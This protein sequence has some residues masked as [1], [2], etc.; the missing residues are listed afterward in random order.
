M[1]AQG[2][3]VKEA[4]RVI[5]LFSDAAKLSKRA[6]GNEDILVPSR[7]VG[8]LLLSAARPLGLLDPEAL[9]A[10]APTAAKGDVGVPIG[11]LV[12]WWFDD[13]WP[14]KGEREKAAAEEEPVAVAD[15]ATA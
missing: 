7:F 6:D 11:M 2:V 1:S 15:E 4:Q 12:R 3:D 10:T 9:V 13:V 14:R 5:A 8:K